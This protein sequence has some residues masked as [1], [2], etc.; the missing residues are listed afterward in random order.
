MAPP[1]A[2][3]ALHHRTPLLLPRRATATATA[4]AARAAS[5]AVRAAQPDTT[6]A[7]ASTSA[8]E[9]PAL[10]FKPPPGFKVPEPKRFEV[11][12]GQQNSVLGASLAIPLRLGT[13]VFVLGYAPYRAFS[14]HPRVYLA[15]GLQPAYTC[16]PARVTSICRDTIRPI[17]TGIW[18][19]H[20]SA[21]APAS[22]SSAWKVKEESKIGQCK[23]PEKPIEIY[24]FE[25]CPF[26]RK[27]RE[28]VSV[29]DLDVLFYPCPQKGPTFRPKVLEMG[30]KKQFP[31]MV[32]PNTG[33]AMYESDDIIKYLADTYGDGTVPIMLSLG[34]L[35]TI[36]AGLATLGRFGKGNSYT[37]SKVPPQPI[38]IWAYE[39]S[40]FC[41]L[42]RETL[43]ELELPHL[44]HS[45][46]R[47]SPKRQDFLKK[48][49]VFQAPYIEDPNT[50]VQMFESAEII[51]YL[52]GT[53][54]LYPSS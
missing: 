7:S 35:T 53:Y 46:A 16:L 8:P 27:V 9:P 17:R 4:R 10:E 43:V 21:S 47:G 23:R 36:T 52:K 49:G 51:D 2:P 41:R 20:P 22:S 48:K 26:C 34:L 6:A 54:A 5:L 11:K 45:C 31:Y 40:P 50:G 30:G 15:Y 12:P 3:T 33:V 42:V 39:G 32:D 38:K 18:R 25:G 37:A 19:L 13:G 24:E 28:M 29:L 1:A 44:L 14:R